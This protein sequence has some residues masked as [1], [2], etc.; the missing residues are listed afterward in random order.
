M[1]LGLM[2]TLVGASLLGLVACAQIYDAQGKSCVFSSDC[3]N[4]YVCVE[5]IDEDEDESEECLLTDNVGDCIKAACIREPEGSEDIVPPVEWVC[6]DKQYGRGDT[7][8]CG[9]GAVDPDC[10]WQLQTG[11]CGPAGCRTNG[12][13]RCVEGDSIVICK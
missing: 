8:D 9:C 2:G 1:K 5:Y 12:C 6:G 4:G 11:E 7:C 13:Q 10:L 3:A